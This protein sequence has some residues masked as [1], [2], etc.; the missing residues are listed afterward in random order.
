MRRA[1]D[2]AY[3]ILTVLLTVYGQLAIKW[4]MAQAGPLPEGMAAKALFLLRQA[5]S[6]AVA[7]GLGAAALAALSWMAAMTRFPLSVAYPFV[8]L[9]FVLVPLLAT[10][11]LREPLNPWRLAGAALIVLGV[12][13]AGL[14]S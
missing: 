1:G 9:S 2:Y 5:A 6:P 3:V 7:S 11:V 12:I 4:Q 13:V 14:G 10:V 8:A